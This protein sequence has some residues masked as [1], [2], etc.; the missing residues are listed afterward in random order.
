MPEVQGQQ[1]D[2]RTPPLASLKDESDEWLSALACMRKHPRSWK[3]TQAVQELAGK[4][5]VSPKTAERKLEKLA[6]TCYEGQQANLYYVV[7][8]IESLKDSVTPVTFVWHQK[9]DETQF[10]VKIAA[11]ESELYATEAQ[12]SKIFVVETEWFMVVKSMPTALGYDHDCD[13][14]NFMY[15]QGSFSTNL[16]TAD[17]NT[18]EAIALVLRSVPLPPAKVGGLFKNK[19]GL[20]KQMKLAQISKANDSSSHGSHH[21][22]LQQ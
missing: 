14:N 10:L 19:S 5:N 13:R 20:Q 9:Y 1:L 4:L 15:I 22:G 3:A 12:R 7:D 17:S 16:R 6:E 11:G 8:Y 2:T 21:K 18:G